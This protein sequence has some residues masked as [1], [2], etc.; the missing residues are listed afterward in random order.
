MDP[1]LLRAFVTI[2]ETGGFTSAAERLNR[3][4]G[5]VSQQIRRLEEVTGGPVFR[6]S[7]AGVSLTEAGQRLLP[8][9]RAILDAHARVLEEF[10]RTEIAGPVSLG[11]PEIFAERLVPQVLSTFH[12]QYPQVRINLELRDT[13]VLIEQLRNGELDLSFATEGE[14]E[15]LAGYIVLRDEVV[16]IAPHGSNVERRTPLPVVVWH[17]GS[18]YEHVVTSALEE[19]GREFRVVVKTQTMAGMIASVRAGLGIAAVTRSNVN[20]AVRIVPDWVDL[21]KIAPRVVRLERADGKKSKAVNVLHRHIL[22][23]FA[24]R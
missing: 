21:P 8:H 2:T 16:W 15:G 5:A 19:Q 24:Q 1:E 10:D 9:A 12:T 7:A 20:D 14:V 4:Q 17:S 23:S 6:R 13:K 11:M 3:T 22:E 18:N